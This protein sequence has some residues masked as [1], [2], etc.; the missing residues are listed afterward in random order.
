MGRPF[1][2]DHRRPTRAAAGPL[3]GFLVHR[4]RAARRGGVAKLPRGAH[5]RRRRRSAPGA[6]SV[7]LPCRAPPGAGWRGPRTAGHLRRLPGP[8]RMG[9]A[10][11]RRGRPRHG[12]GGRGDDRLPVGVRQ[13]L[14]PGPCRCGGRA[15]RLH[16][17]GRAHRPVRLRPSRPRALRLPHAPNERG[18]VCLRAPGRTGPSAGRADRV[19]PAKRSTPRRG[20]AANGIAA[21]SVRGGRRRPLRHR[22]GRVGR[23][24]TADAPTPAPHR[25]RAG[26]RRHRWT[27]EGQH[28]LRL[29]ADSTRQRGHHDLTHPTR[30]SVRPAR[31]PT[32]PGS[33]ATR[34]TTWPFGP[35]GR[36]ARPCLGGRGCAMFE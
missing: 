8:V 30:P 19:R 28:R 2:P 21:I 12:H 3:L 25:Q 17:L 14:R 34:G 6:R 24:A 33:P 26:H 9:A 13:R 22:P 35:P 10:D 1:R 11:P 23:A 16:R 31:G 29:P 32:W 36:A 18:A 5:P 27:G 15:A 4:R 20:T 7:P